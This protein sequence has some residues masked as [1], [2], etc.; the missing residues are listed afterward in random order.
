MGRKLIWIGGSAVL[1]LAAAYVAVAL[2]LDS[3]VRVGV[4]TFAPRMTLTR[5]VLGGVSLSPITGGG[6]LTDLT[7]GNPAGWSDN[8]ALRF[9]RIHV[10]VAPLSVLGDPIV[11]RDVVIDEPVFNYETKIV[12]SNIGDLLKTMERVSG[13]PEAG[14]AGPTA[15]N[16]KPMR[17]EIRHFLLRGGKIRLGTGDAAIVIPLPPIELNDLGTS[18]G[19]STPAVLALDIMRSVTESVAG[20]TARAAGKIGSTMGAAAG[21]AAKKAGEDLKSLF[22]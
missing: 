17:I 3:A 22:K 20:A 6:T 15:G 5:V 18:E 4:N 9:G 13:S 19:G 11:V 16:G 1:V 12:S 14:S 7:V 10:E 8:D 2:F 21:S